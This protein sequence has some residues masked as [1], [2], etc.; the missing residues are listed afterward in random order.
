M[1]LFDHQL[2][3]E[4]DCNSYTCPICEWEEE[5]LAEAGAPPEEP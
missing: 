3:R 1:T 5:Q 4:G 2:H